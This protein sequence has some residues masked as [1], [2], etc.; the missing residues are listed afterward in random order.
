MHIWRRIASND[1]L[2]PVIVFLHGGGY[3]LGDIPI[4]RQFY[5]NVAVATKMTTIGVEYRL[6]PE[7]QFPG[8]MISQ[9]IV[10]NSLY[11]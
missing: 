1:D 11:V 6:A 2:E 9:K 7:T 5:S 8:K 3:M 4:H 10:Q